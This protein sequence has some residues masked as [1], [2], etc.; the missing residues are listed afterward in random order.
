MEGRMLTKAALDKVSQI[1]GFLIA[2]G[3]CN[4]GESR[5]IKL[6]CESLRHRQLLWSSSCSLIMAPGGIVIMILTLMLVTTLNDPLRPLPQ[7]RCC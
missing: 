2:K 1:K 5:Y 4:G 7:L 3:E 6:I